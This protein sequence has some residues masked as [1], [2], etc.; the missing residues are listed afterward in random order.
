MPF[1]DPFCPCTD[2]GIAIHEV[3]GMSAD[4]VAKRRIRS[5]LS[6]RRFERRQLPASTWRR[7]IF[8]GTLATEGD[9]CLL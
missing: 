5:A 1:V 4:F 6:P 8:R 3:A 9:T 2:I 7:R